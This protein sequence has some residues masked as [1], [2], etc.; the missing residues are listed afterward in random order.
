VNAPNLAFATQQGQ[1]QV[2]QD[3]TPEP[4]TF[5]LMAAGLILLLRRRLRR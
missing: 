4:G 2:V 1:V 5:P 3:A